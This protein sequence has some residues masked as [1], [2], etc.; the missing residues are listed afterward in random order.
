MMNDSGSWIAL[1]VGGASIKAAHA[2]G[3]AR[4][5]P[6]ELWKRPDELGRVLA[7]LLATL[8]PGA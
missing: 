3:P 4:T 7:T 2:A 6:F 8:L 5:L 1:D